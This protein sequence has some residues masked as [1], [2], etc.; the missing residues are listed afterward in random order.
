MYDDAVDP[1]KVFLPQGAQDQTRRLWWRMM[2]GAE[3]MPSILPYEQVMHEGQH[4]HAYGFM[5]SENSLE[6]ASPPSCFAPR[7][8][9]L[10]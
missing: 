10:Y 2:A 5:V 1:M 7:Q 6:V 3:S 9:V 4:I 8:D